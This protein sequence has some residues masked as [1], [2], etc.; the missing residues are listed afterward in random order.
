MKRIKILCLC[1]VVAALFCSA[2]LAGTTASADGTDEVFIPDETL[3]SA[4]VETLE[5]STGVVTEND[6]KKLTGLETP[7]NDP[8]QKIKDLT[9]MEYAVNLVSLNLDYNK[10]TD[11]TPIAGLTKLESLNIS[12]NDGA[13][14]GTDGI[15]DV[16]C[17]EGLVNLKEFSSVGNSGVSDYSVVAN[18][19]NLTYL[20]LSICGIDDVS[21]IGGLTRLEKLYLSYN[22]VSDIFP[23]AGL[24]SLKTLAIGNNKIADVSVVANFKELTQLTFENNY[25]DDFSA[26]EE[27]NLLNYLD[28][29]R[30]FLTDE[31]MAQLM[32]KVDA[33]TVFV[34]P[35]AEESKKTGLFCLNASACT[36][37]VGETFGI[38]AA[39]IS[40]GKKVDATFSSTDPSVA[41]VGADGK[42]TAVSEGNCYILVRYNGF[43]R[44]VILT[45]SEDAPEDSSGGGDS[46]SAVSA[47]GCKGSGCGSSLGSATSVLFVAAVGVWFFVSA[48]RRKDEKK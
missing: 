11:L 4:I 7:V 16:S 38:S 42:V 24:T 18:F 35:V 3:K 30:N 1:F 26:V 20:N 46:D 33:E 2:G 19:K 10:I 32:E 21:F 44:G 9:G 43:T 34:S 29:S 27:L 6:M 28:V 48:I 25:V 23:L 22:T 8:A 39:D 41:T 13:T 14:E 12:Y 17:L 37:A 47:K 31:Q 45:V 36:L 40:D 5:L 15:T